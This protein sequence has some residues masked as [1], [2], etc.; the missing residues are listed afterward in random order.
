MLAL[1]RA[2][3][4][5]LP[6]PDGL[7]RQATVCVFTKHMHEFHRP[8]GHTAAIALRSSNTLKSGST[9]SN[10]AQRQ[11]VLHSPEHTDLAPPGA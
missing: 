2:D 7:N 6:R 3:G 5:E 10:R 4:V 9:V 1:P 8:A 11:E